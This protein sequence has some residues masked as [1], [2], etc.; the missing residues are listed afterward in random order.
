MEA[1]PH[2]RIDNRLLH[3]QVVQ[4]WLPYLEVGRLIIADDSAASHRT[5]RTVF[6]MAVPQNV[7]V[8]IVPI[9]KLRHMLSSQ[10]GSAPFIIVSDVFDIARAAMCGVEFERV[11]LG[12]VHTSSDRARVTDS[13]YLSPEETS[14]LAHF[15]GSG[16]EVEVQ[17]FPGEVLKLKVNGDGGAEWT[18]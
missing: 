12:N 6:R 1:L 14:A 18:R 4:F 8:D 5:M 13:V 2:I 15:V 9:H 7:E 16:I 11:T 10:E 3:G 17:T